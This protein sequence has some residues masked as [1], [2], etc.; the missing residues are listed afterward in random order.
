MQRILITLATFIFIGCGSQENN[1]S[2][3]RLENP[4]EITVTTHKNDPIKILTAREMM[5]LT[6]STNKPL[7][8]VYFTTWCPSCIAEIPELVALDSE[9]KGEISIIGVLL[10]P[11]YEE[12]K[13]DMFIKQHHITYQLVAPHSSFE[14]GKIVGGIR[15]IPQMFL[16]DA[17]GK[18]VRHYNGPEK[19]E[20]LQLDINTLKGK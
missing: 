12:E 13:V 15:S 3:V 14:L 20:V 9:N 19:K 6:P 2:T 1:I 18:L 11:D 5:Q 4:K 17:S 10:E 16:Y 8:M 7:L